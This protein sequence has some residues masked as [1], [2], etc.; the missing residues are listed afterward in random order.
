[1]GL[2]VLLANEAGGACSA[3]RPS[4]ESEVL[5]VS[6]KQRSRSQR[7]GT[8]AASAGSGADQSRRKGIAGAIQQPGDDSPQSR[9]VHYELYLYLPERRARKTFEQHDPQPGTRETHLAE[10][11][12]LYGA[13]FAC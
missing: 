12:E 8:T 6:S 1:M 4:C 9:R 5:M 3:G 10:R 2:Y 13:S 11:S 7:N